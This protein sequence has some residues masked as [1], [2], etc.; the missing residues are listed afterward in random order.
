MPAIEALEKVIE[1][2]ETKTEALLITGNCDSCD[3][4]AAFQANKGNLRLVFC[5]HHI[6][7]NAASLQD[8][9]FAIQPENYKFG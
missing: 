1:K 8:R 7:Q 4:K 9:G 5:G 2:D 3:S 6:R